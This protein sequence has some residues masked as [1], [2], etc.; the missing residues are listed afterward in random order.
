M[1][2]AAI[3]NVWIVGHSEISCHAVLGDH[4]GT[5][6]QIDEAKLALMGSAPPRTC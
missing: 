2:R 5:L 4:V 3:F 6:G 1:L